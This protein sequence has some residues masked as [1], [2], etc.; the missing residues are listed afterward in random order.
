MASIRRLPSGKWQARYRLVPNGR[1]YTKT[2]VRKVDAQRWLD[3][4]TAKIQTGT[5]TDPKTSRVSVGDW[6]DTWLDGY[7]TRRGSTVRQAKVHL[8]VIRDHFGEMRLGSVRPSHVKSWTTKLRDD[9][10]EASYIYALHARLAQVMSDAVHDGI[11]PRSPCSRRTSPP[12]AAQRPY[13]ATTDQV[14][15]LHDA[16]PQHLRAA[17]L[18]GAFAGLRVGEACGLRVSDVDFMRGVITPAVQY[19]AE[20]LKTESSRW[21]VPI[22]K[23][24]TLELSDHVASRPARDG[25]DA[26]LTDMWGQQL[27]PWTLERAM[28]DARPTVDGL[29]VGFRYH[30][31]RHYFASLLISDGADIKT[32]QTRLRHGSATTTLRTYAHMWPD[33]DETT[34]ATVER[35]IV[36]RVARTEERLRNGEVIT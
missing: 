4:Q 21:P 13:V 22:P 18:L 11:I 12:A 3:E 1:Q 23:S 10:Y 17:I 34:R 35:V 26:L 24:L 2:T 25:V 20:P 19:P 5:W 29:P 8:S 16:F 9:G 36:A 14:W 32:V 27:A 30:D 28:R 33:K 31:L 15:A 7:G 6:L